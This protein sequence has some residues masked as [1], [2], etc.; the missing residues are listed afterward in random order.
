M[1]LS[2]NGLDCEGT[3]C[4]CAS[5]QVVYEDFRCKSLQVP[6]EITELEYESLIK[7]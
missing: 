3:R 4:I 7:K 5:K 6:F 2:A 1:T